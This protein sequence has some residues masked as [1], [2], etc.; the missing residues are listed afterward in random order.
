M[1]EG[2]VIPDEFKF[3]V[4]DDIVEQVGKTLELDWEEVD[5]EQFK[6]GLQVEQE[7]FDV[8]NGDP[9][10]TGRIALVHLKEIAD[11]YTRLDKME[12]EAEHKD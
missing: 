9:T 6:R 8:T 7:H 11:Y 1:L 12:K 4:T 10:I 2:L 5:K 3:E